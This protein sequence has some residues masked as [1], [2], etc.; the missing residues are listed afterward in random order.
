[1]TPAI[2]HGQ[3]IEIKIPSVMRLAKPFVMRHDQ[4]REHG[5]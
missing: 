2:E 4:K 1:M 3:I 5:C